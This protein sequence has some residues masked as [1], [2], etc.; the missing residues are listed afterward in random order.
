MNMIN[1]C[2]EAKKLKI[3]TFAIVGFDGGKLKKISKI[4]FILN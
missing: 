1:A 2:K 3:D 4:I